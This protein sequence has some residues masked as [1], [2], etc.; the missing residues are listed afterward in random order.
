MFY[1]ENLGLEFLAETD[2][3]IT[4]LAGAVCSE[5]KLIQGYYDTPY[6]NHEFGDS[7]FIART[8][9]TGEKSLAL[10]G[11]DIHVVGST[12]WTFAISH[13][14]SNSDDDPLSRRVV[15]HKLDDGTGLCVIDLVNADVLP[16][17]ME[18]DEITAQMIGFPINISYYENEDAYANDQPEMLN[19]G[20][21]LFADGAVFPVGLMSDKKDKTKDDE[22][23]MMIR[24]TVKSAYVGSVEFGEE[25]WPSFIKVIITTQFGDLEIVHTEDQIEK[26]Q[27]KFIKAGSV[28]N[29]LFR[30]SGDV[31]IFDYEKGRIKDF[32]HNLALMRYTLQKGDAERLRSVLSDDAEYYSEWANETYHGKDAIID[33]FIWVKEGNTQ[34]P[35]F[36]HFATITEIMDGEEEVCHEVG[37][38][39]I[40]IARETE[41]NLESICF[42]D[43]NDDNQIS[44]IEVTK[45]P[46]YRFKIDEEKVYHKLM[47]D[48]EPTTDVCEAIIARAHFHWFLDR[49][50]SREDIEEQS[51]Y[52]RYYNKAAKK[53]V[54][55]MKQNPLEDILEFLP[56]VYSHLFVKS[57]EMQLSDNDITKNDVFPF[58][59]ISLEEI[60][61]GYEPNG[62]DEFI[63]KR[64]SASYELA[65]QFY[66]DFKFRREMADTEDGFEDELISSLVL[67]Q[68]I[69]E[70]YAR[71]KLMKRGD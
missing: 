28:V 2:D 20:K 5:G 61:G 36:A 71:T 52:T 31:A 16:S 19:G 26:D 4:A 56:K 54:R 10:N 63:T 67:I 59:M 8:T 43:C 70:F 50:I 62:W 25:K 7:Q 69:A 53:I 49:E 11:L 60:S 21:M 55:E 41:D 58:S 39:C 15:A 22:A 51:L 45:N 34:R 35:F 3:D 44:R 14:T 33:R 42:I 23:I 40:I 57:I 68:Q 29:G 12:V 17:F 24:G 47:E 9:R 66:K 32:K 27:R 38:R 13:E 1:I 65:S 30:L 46:R 64:L 6:V 48:Y 37:D 18:H